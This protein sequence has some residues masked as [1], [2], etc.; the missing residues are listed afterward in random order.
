MSST[1]W[2][3]NLKHMLASLKKGDRVAVMAE[4]G[5]VSSGSS[6]FFNIGKRTHGR[7]ADARACVGA[8]AA[9]ERLCPAPGFCSKLRVFFAIACLSSS[10]GFYSQVI[11]VSTLE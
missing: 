10:D 7:R 6:L 9:R 1:V 11:V 2:L 3:P 4:T 8:G 5:A